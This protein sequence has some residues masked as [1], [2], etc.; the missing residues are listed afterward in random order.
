MQYPK[1]GSFWDQPSDAAMYK[2]LLIRLVIG[3]VVGTIAWFIGRY[4]LRHLI[5]H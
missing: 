5:L 4:I 3:I 1:K 2:Y